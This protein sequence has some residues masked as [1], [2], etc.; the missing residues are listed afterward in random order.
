MPPS[1][2]T[3]TGAPDPD[4]DAHAARIARTPAPPLVTGVLID[5]D[6]ALGLRFSDVDDA[7]AIEFAAR[8]GLPLAG[9]TTCFGNAPLEQTDRIARELGERLDL[10]VFTGASRPGQA[11]SPAVDALIAH[12]GTVVALAPLTNI[13]AA[14]LRGARWERLIVLG[15]TDRRMPN[16]RPLHTTEL[17][18]AL[19]PD[20]AIV[21]LPRC[22]VLFPMEVCRQVRFGRAEVDRMPAWLGDR[23]RHWLRLAPLLTGRRSFHPWDLLPIVWLALP[24][25]FTLVPARAEARF[26]PTRRGYV[27]YVPGDCRVAVKVDADGLIRTWDP[28][29]SR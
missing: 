29:S 18:L 14:L 22:D 21:A 15:G 2:G 25:L 6:P 19:D 28:T 27:R 16:L 20:A 12:T 17:N 13:A 4:T 23:C 9:L 26:L 8:A 10:P 1:A 7:I 3:Y 11:D 5:T 24:S